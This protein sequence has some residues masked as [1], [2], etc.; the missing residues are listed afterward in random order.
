M[1][2]SEMLSEVRDHGFDDLTDTRIL[3]FLND[4][5]WDI[6]SREAWPF[7]EA[8]AALV[9]DGTG[10]VT[11]PD[12]VSKVLSITANTAGSPNLQPRDLGEF[13]K[14]HGEELALT[15]TPHTY[16]FVGNNVYVYPIPASSDH[17]IRYIRNPDAL[18]VSPDSSPILP[19]QHHR[20]IVLGSLV[21]CYTLEDDPEQAGIFTNMYEQRLMQMRNDLWRRQFDRTDVIVDM[22]SDA[23]D[24]WI[25]GVY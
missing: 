8:S 20:V 1:L 10:L 6:C 22:E 14:M 17:T 9:T 7:L 16:Y 11:S 12:D 13:S 23:T 5:Y 3:G 25:D 18:T 15:G 4:T 19:T 2:V 21:K 24:L